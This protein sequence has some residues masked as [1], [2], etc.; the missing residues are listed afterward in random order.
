VMAVLQS[1]VISNMGTIFR[2]R[3]LGFILLSV[4][5]GIGVYEIWKKNSSNFFKA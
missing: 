4:F 3:T 1:M 5:T 2:H